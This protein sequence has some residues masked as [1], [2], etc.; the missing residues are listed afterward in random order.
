MA[1]YISNFW[2]TQHLAYTSICY[3]TRPLLLLMLLLLSKAVVSTQQSLFDESVDKLR[4]VHMTSGQWQYLWV[5]PWWLD[6]RVVSVLDWGAEGPGF[7]SQP[8]RCRVTVCSYP[9]CLCSPSSKIGSSP[10]E[11]T[12]IPFLD[13]NQQYQVLKWA[14]KTTLPNLQFLLHQLRITRINYLLQQLHPIPLQSFTQNQRQTH[15]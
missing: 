12:Y 11:R 8:R 3:L 1:E 13:P 14:T 7:K 5:G 9:L 10:L 15:R 6:S 4:V 2:H